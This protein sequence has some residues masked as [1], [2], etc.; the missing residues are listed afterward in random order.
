MLALLY[1][2]ICQYFEI[3]YPLSIGKPVRILENGLAIPDYLPKDS[4]ILINTVPSVIEYL[5]NEKIDL[6]KVSVINMA[7]E[8]IPSRVLDGLHTINT[9]VRNLYGPTEDTTYSTISRLEK[10]ET[11]D[12]HRQTDSEYADIYNKRG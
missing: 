12:Y 2:L 4:F 5:I 3:F 6:S 1:V 10:R 8:P 9:E 11:G 7:G